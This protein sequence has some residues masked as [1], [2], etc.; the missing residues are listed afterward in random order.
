MKDAML[1]AEKS[2]EE[3]RQW[4]DTN[5]QDFIPVRN[6]RG[7]LKQVLSDFEKKRIA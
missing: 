6:L 1:D 4:S 7:K 5:K 3:V 2:F